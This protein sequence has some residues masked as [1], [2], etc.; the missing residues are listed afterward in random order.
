MPYALL[1]KLGLMG[2]LVSGMFIA[3]WGLT[4]WHARRRAPAQVASFLGSCTA[5]LLAEMTNPLVLN[6]VSVSIFACLL[7][8]WAHLVSQ[9][10]RTEPSSVG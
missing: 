7:F 5:L 9:P 8:Q 1:A 10:D 2:V 6:F 4:A 3:G